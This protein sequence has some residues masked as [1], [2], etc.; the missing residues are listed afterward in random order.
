MSA[1]EGCTDLAQGARIRMA[2]MGVRLRDVNFQGTRSKLRKFNAT[3]SIH[4]LTRAARSDGRDRPSLLRAA[5]LTL[6]T[7]CVGPAM[8]RSAGFPPRKISSTY[9]AA[10]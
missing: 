8:G 9:L 10:P 1:I 2:D 6:M 3:Q 5:R 7:N 4:S